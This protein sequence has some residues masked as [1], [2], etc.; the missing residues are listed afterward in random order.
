MNIFQHDLKTKQD[1]KGLLRR[2]QTSQEAARNSR[3]SENQ[4]WLTSMQTRTV[5]LEVLEL[6]MFDQAHH[7]A[8]PT[9][10][11]EGQHPF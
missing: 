7:F 3:L 6:L 2:L 10:S 8:A 11:T 9:E 4:N 5:V 1:H